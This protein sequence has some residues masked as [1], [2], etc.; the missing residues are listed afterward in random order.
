LQNGSEKSEPFFYDPL[1]FQL[2]LGRSAPL[3][4]LKPPWLARLTTLSRAALRR[5]APLKRAAHA[6]GEARTQ[7]DNK[8]VKKS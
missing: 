4:S 7:P 5:F 8:S 2:P 3:R 6:K 1:R